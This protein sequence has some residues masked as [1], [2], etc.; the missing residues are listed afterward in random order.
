M[1][2]KVLWDPNLLRA[3]NAPIHIVTAIAL[4][5]LNHGLEKLTMRGADQSLHILQDEHVWL[6]ILNERQDAWKQVS[7][8][9]AVT[10]TFA[11]PCARPRLARKARCIDVRRFRQGGGFPLSQIVVDAALFTAIVNASR[12]IFN[13]IININ[14][15]SSGEA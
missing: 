8:P 6:G 4:E 11:F 3:E 14:I 10:L 15:G 5:T 1:Q 9:L 7:T 13:D 12:P 2:E